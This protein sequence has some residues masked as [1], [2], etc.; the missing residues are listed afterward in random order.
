[1]D[2]NTQ[3][4]GLTLQSPIVASAGPITAELDNI[5][6]LADLGAGAVVMPSI[7]EEQIEQERQLVENLD[8]FAADRYAEALTYFPSSERYKIGPD[9]YLEVLRTAV[10]AVDIPVIASLNGTT[11]EIWVDY[12][13]QIE[14]AGARALELNI[15]MVPMDLNVPGREI[16][17]RYMSIVRAV[18][19]GVKIPVAVKISPY[20]SSIG[21]MAVRLM[22][23]GASGLVLF[24][25]F[26][27]PDIDLAELAL[28]P[29]LDLSTAKE[30]RLALLWIGVLSGR[31][32]GS[33]AAS[34]GV[35]SADE[36]IKYLL[37]GADV[38][39]TT[40]ALLKHGVGHMK[41]LLDGLKCWLGARD[42]Q[43]LDRVRGRLSQ[44]NVS[45]PS[46]FARANYI[47][48]LQ[49]YTAKS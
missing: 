29:T 44:R 2:L 13:R 4:L 30:I 34:T 20:F 37:A 18:T 7:F 38:V 14:S 10:N 5:R 46:A 49:G 39:M 40:S 28:A 1:M 25:R 6:R 35:E 22:G 17:L 26:Y 23:A 31:I 19:L 33:L 11:N 43:N 15:Y 24:N 36:V 3:Y 32:N 42:L 21:N 9:R 12:A 16:E 45:D 41:V 8:E 47:R 48:I 27:Q